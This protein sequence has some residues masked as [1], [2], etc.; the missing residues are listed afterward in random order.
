MCFNEVIEGREWF[1]GSIPHETG[2]RRKKMKRFSVMMCIIG[3]DEE[4]ERFETDDFAE[5][6]TVCKAYMVIHKG[7]GRFCFYIKDHKPNLNH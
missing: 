5:A 2:T 4:I 6:K 3:S 1:P 7:N